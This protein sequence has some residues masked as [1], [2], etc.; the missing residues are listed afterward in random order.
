MIPPNYND[1][2]KLDIHQCVNS[3]LLFNKFTECNIDQL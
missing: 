1:T 2:L 3:N